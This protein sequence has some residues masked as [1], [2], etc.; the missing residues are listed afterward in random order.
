MAYTQGQFGLIKES[1]QQESQNLLARIS[2][3]AESIDSSNNIQNFTKNQIEKE[4]QI[5]TELFI[6]NNQD[7]TIKKSVKAKINRLKRQRKIQMERLCALN[8]HKNQFIVVLQ[9]NQSK[10]NQNQLKKI[11]LTDDYT[12][13]KQIALTDLNQSDRISENNQIMVQPI[14]KLKLKVENQNEKIQNDLN[15]QKNVNLVQEAQNQIEQKN[16]SKQHLSV[17]NQQDVLIKNINTGFQEFTLLT[18]EEDQQGKQQMCL[19]N[20]KNNQKK[21]FLSILIQALCFFISKLCEKFL[22]CI[23]QK[24][25]DGNLQQIQPDIEKQLPVQKLQQGQISQNSNQESGENLISPNKKHKKENQQ[26][27]SNERIFN[28]QED[29]QLI[30]LNQDAQNQNKQISLNQN[31]P[32]RKKQSVIQALE[33]QHKVQKSEQAEISLNQNQVLGENS[34]STNKKHKKEN[35]QSNSNERIFDGQEDSQ[36]ISLSQDAQNQNKQ[37]SLNQNVPKRKKQSNI[38]AMGMQGKVQKSEK[39]EISQNQNQ[40]KAEIMISSNKKLTKENQQSKLKTIKSG[41]EQQYLKPL[42]S[43]A[44]NE[45][46]QISL[47]IKD[48]KD[49]HSQTNQQI[50]IALQEQYDCI[51]YQQNQND[52]WLPGQYLN[53]G[54]LNEK[55][56]ESNQINFTQLDTKIIQNQESVNELQ[57]LQDLNLY[58]DNNQI[59][60][61]QIGDIQNPTEIQYLSQEEKNEPQIYQSDCKVEDIQQEIQIFNQ[62]NKNKVT[63]QNFTQ[64]QK[65][66]FQKLKQF[67]YQICQTYYSSNFEDIFYGYRKYNNLLKQ[68]FVFK[69]L[70]NLSK[71]DKE[72]LENTKYQINESSAIYSRQNQDMESAIF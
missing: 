57:Q 47:L 18:V 38:Q 42:I 54:Q 44:L 45:N 32:K 51:Q 35:Q 1:K 52:Q 43:D 37:T 7:N 53:Y 5:K 2:L 64:Y 29:Q 66:I 19:R 71:L 11:K 69:I 17:M 72:D 60:F 65:Q 15:K 4:I 13:E 50:Q 23:K 61:I 55:V 28:Q 8:A 62:S 58:D 41:Q 10:N 67:E 14:S 31:V 9:S 24:P 3:S 70:Y 48:I 30:F 26:S 39:A 46:N 20:D 25:N 21:C 33:I 22:N 56:D 40:E 12:N 49:S 68:D 59:V 36:L 63:S 27:K 34:I 16:N 6:Q